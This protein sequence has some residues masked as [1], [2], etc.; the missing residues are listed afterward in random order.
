MGSTSPWDTFESR[1]E[2]WQSSGCHQAGLAPKPGLLGFIGTTRPELDYSERVR[3]KSIF[4]ASLCLLATAAHARNLNLF[5]FLDER[6]SD[7]LI[8]STTSEED[9][10]EELEEGESLLYLPL[11]D[12]YIVEG[13]SD[14]E[15]R[16]DEIELTEGVEWALQDTQCDPCTFSPDD[17][18]SAGSFWYFTPDHG[19]AFKWT[20]SAPFGWDVIR[21]ATATTPVAVVDSGVG[22]V[23]GDV[24]M[25]EDLPSRQLG[26]AVYRVRNLDELSLL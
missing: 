10:E 2:S 4:V 14:V 19:C 16:A 15:E 7:R 22:S 23:V 6:T 21:S 12:L 25:H 13:V 20:G 17:D 5:T 9:L 18:T 26:V 8:V 11:L 1:L 24:A 3:A